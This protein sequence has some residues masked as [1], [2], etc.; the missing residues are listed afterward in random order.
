MKKNYFLL[1]FL[2]ILSARGFAQVGINN[3]N[4]SA[5]LDVIGDVLI[6]DKL[7]LE[8]PGGDL[9]VTNSKLL[10]IKDNDTQISKY[11]IEM[12]SY[13]P[14]NYI[15][16]LFRDVSE[17]GLRDGFNTKISAEKYTIAVHGYYLL[18][19]ADQTT[20]VSFRS[21]ANN[22]NR[23]ME[24]HRYYA[25]IQD[26]EWWI[27]GFVQNSRS[28]RFW[29]M[30]TDIYMDVTIYK[31]DFISKRWDNTIDVNMGKNTTKTVA[32]PEGF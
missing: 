2:L 25:Y 1:A 8:N 7:Y 14:L 6:Q 4:P 5:T 31:N 27:K 16:F 29:P 15:K 17:F 18:I 24:G 9:N 19:H 11:D 30:N 10:V 20:N 3:P 21:Q 12:S 26:G 28:Y 32:T 23:Y 13:G 22:S